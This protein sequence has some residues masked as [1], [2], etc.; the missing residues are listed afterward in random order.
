MA[1][2]AGH[3]RGEAT[4]G[5]RGPDRLAAEQ[6]EL[7]L[8]VCNLLSRHREVVAAEHREVG[9]PAG[10]EGSARL[11]FEAEPR[12]SSRVSAQ[13]L[14]TRQEIGVVAGPLS[15]HAQSIGVPAQCR[16]GQVGR[17]TQCVGAT[18]QRNPCI[19]DRAQRRRG[20]HP[21]RPAGIQQAVALEPEE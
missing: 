5:R 21:F 8:E 20:P 3:L 11:L 18:A 13:R 16:E 15:G 10:F 4:K 14:L 9:Q 12:S 2:S 19:Q 17:D 1:R 7:G 6:G